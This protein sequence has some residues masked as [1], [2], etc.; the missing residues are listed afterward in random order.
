MNSQS[1]FPAAVTSDY[2]AVAL[3]YR[4]NRFSALAIMPNDGSLA[5]FTSAL[6]ADRL[7]AI[8]GNLNST[9]VDLSM[10]KFETSSTIDL[11]PILEQMGV[12]DAFSDHADLSGIGP[13]LTV[14]QVIQRTYLKVAE[15]GTEAAAATGVGIT[16]TAIP[17][18][19]ITIDL[20]HPF[21]FLIRDNV[22][23]AVLFAA[24]IQN[25]R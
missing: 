11:G 6:T 14:S 7:A 13:N 17:A 4:G 15:K 8:V 20:D 19:R 1:T 3:P 23:G 2:S 9:S 24:Q 22:T 10:P 5:Q 25:P 21:L 16:S 18:G 12:R